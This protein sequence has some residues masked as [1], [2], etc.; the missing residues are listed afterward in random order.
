MPA[1]SKAFSIPNVSTLVESVFIIPVLPRETIVWDLPPY[2]YES[3]TAPNLKRLSD[4][5]QDSSVFMIIEPPFAYTDDVM[6]ASVGNEH[7]IRQK[8]RDANA[9]A[10]YFIFQMDRCV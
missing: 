4:V 10:M 1:E 8:T 2:S 7:N 3:L 6:I 5:S 9:N